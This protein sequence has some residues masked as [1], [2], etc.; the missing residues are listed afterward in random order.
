[1]EFDEVA[2]YFIEEEWRCL[3][4][5]QK[6]LYKE[7]MMENWQTLRTLGFLHVTPSIVSKI[8][9]GED[10]CVCAHQKI[11]LEKTHL[12][13]STGIF[14]VKNTV[15]YQDMVLNASF[16]EDNNLG[17]Y[18]QEP[19]H[20]MENILTKII[21]TEDLNLFADEH[22]D[23]KETEDIDSEHVANQVF[24]YKNLNVKVEKNHDDLSANKSNYNNIEE[25]QNETFISMYTDYSNWK[26]KD[27]N[28]GLV[29]TQLI[30]LVMKSFICSQCGKM[31]SSKSN[32]NSH[33]RTH[34]GGKPFICPECNRRFSLK[35]SLV[36]HLRI[37]TG[38]KPF[39]CSECGKCFN[40][41]A[42]LVTHKRI[43]SGEKPYSC[44][45]CGK[46]FGHKANLILH[47]KIHRGVKAFA[48]SECEKCFFGKS[49][50]IVHKKKHTIDKQFVCTECGKCFIRNSDLVVHTRGHTG[51][52]PYAC[53]ECGKCYIS[54]SNLVIH[55]RTHT[56]EKPYMCS[57]CEKCYSRSSELFIHN[58][59]HTGE[60]PFICSECGRGFI[61]RSHLSRHKATHFSV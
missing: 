38:K 52:K 18:H 34:E 32:L 3:T 47:E 23:Y 60:K 28:L 8:E 14:T 61:R 30:D 55:K 25:N 16:F 40:R 2:V 43:H 1:M 53:S 59:T 12:N 19:N 49:E 15:D 33:E 58:R 13:T 37:H 39:E 45:E 57:K 41:S 51:E 9:R 48:C 29:K 6:Q 50:L 56:G 46:N 26:R 54:K 17:K 44:S 36:R 42:N 24:T 35:G 11:D 5:E 10:P 22:F 31:F 20:V 27:P 21:K 7:V 4:E